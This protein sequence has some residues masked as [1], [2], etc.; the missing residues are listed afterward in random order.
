MIIWAI[1][2]TAAA[3]ILICIWTLYR[4]QV[5]LTCRQLA[6][7]N[8]NKTNLRLTSQQ[9]FPELNALIDGMNEVIDH[10]RQIEKNALDNESQLKSTITSLSHDIRTPLTSLDGYFQLLL[11]S[12]SREER[13]RYIKIIQ[14]RIKSL[15]DMLE[16]LFTYTKLQDH[17]YE[18]EPT[19][20]D[21][22][23]CVFD[24]VFSF[25]EEF[26]ARGIEPEADFC[27]GHF[28][29]SGNEEALRRTIQNLVKNALV[30]GHSWIAFSMFTEDGHVGFSCSNDTL[31]PEEIQMDQIFRR[32]YKA[33][34]ARTHNS[35]GLGLSIAAGLTRRMGGTVSADLED[36]I[37]SVRVLFPIQTG[38][39]L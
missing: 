34:S 20:I 35:T 4:R 3:I 26:Q 30:H 32:F 9:P 28:Y 15:N 37:F 11:T 7:L 27:Q 18:L 1:A 25:Y 16:E 33:D 31:H 2:A 21:F 10:S 8:E 13:E 19:T 38:A 29:I 17:E 23:K 6:F 12:T 39:L 14:T 5:K 24:T 22:G 36:D